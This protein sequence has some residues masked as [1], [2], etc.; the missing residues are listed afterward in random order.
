[1]AKTAKKKDESYKYILKSSNK[2]G[3][4]FKAWAAIEG[5]SIN[6]GLNLLMRY[7][8]SGDFNYKEM[9]RKAKKVKKAKA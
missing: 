6:K 4:K 5:L 1:M 3:M 8:A 9:L 2:L 7:A